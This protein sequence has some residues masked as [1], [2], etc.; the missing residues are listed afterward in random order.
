MRKFT[1]LD[2]IQHTLFARFSAVNKGDN[3]ILAAG[4]LG[5][6]PDDY[7]SPNLLGG[8]KM[9]EKCSMV[10]GK[11][12]HALWSLGEIT[13]GGRMKEG[14][15]K[16]QH[17]KVVVAR[18]GTKSGK[19]E[20]GK[21]LDAHLKAKFD[22]EMAARQKMLRELTAT[23]GGQWRLVSARHHSSGKIQHDKTAKVGDKKK[24]NY[25]WCFCNGSDTL[26]RKMVKKMLKKYDHNCS[27][28]CQL[29]PRLIY[30]S[31]N[32]DRLSISRSRWS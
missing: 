25:N 21:L 23:K 30:Y 17:V 8:L 10:E 4:S 28:N 18:G 29:A 19:M 5:F 13:V 12:V 15:K 9:I 27:S 24:H 1:P 7:V 11:Q 22:G 3:A 20:P 6:R 16:D 32:R 14:I 31:C 2:G 26:T